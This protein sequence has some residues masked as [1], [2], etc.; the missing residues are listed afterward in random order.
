MAQSE[1]APSSDGATESHADRAYGIWAPALTPMTDDLA[2]DPARF[3]AHLRWLLDNGCHGAAIFGTTGEATSFSV[4]ERIEL[5][6]AALAAGIPA[7]RLMVGTGCCALSDS[8]RLTRHAVESGCGSVLML[9]P[10]YYKG[11]SDEGLFAS[12]AEVIERVG[13]S[14]LGIY[15]YHFPRLSGVPITAGL[16]ERLSAAYPSVI[17]G[18]KDSSGDAQG[19]ADFIARFPDLAIFPGTEALLLDGLRQGGVGSITASAN[20]NAPAIRRVYDAWRRGG[21]EA[22]AGLQEKISAHRTALQSQ[23]LIPTLKRLVA[24]H[25][26]DAAWAN[27]RPPLVAMD[28]ASAVRQDMA[29]AEAGFV[30]GE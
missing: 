4:E 24:R 15:L 10:F 2:P 29:L 22:A 6:E 8:L 14:S 5:L 9:P 7:G 13:S 17:K 25:R 26:G 27:M 11:V 16:T 20:V 18:V 3:V 21:E 1:A 28:E 12:Y 30:F 23:A 19:T